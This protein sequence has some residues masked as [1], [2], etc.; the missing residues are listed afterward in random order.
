MKMNKGT[1]DKP[2]YGDVINAA[3]VTVA[4]KAFFQKSK[5]CYGFTVDNRVVW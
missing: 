4:A 2:H 5:T 1:F 3:V